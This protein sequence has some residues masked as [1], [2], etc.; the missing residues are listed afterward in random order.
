[1][2]V[3]RCNYK[4]KFCFHTSKTSDILPLD[5]ALTGLS[6][7]HQAGVGKINFAGGEPFLHPDF[8]GRL[9]QRSHELGMNVPI[10]SNGSLTTKDWMDQLCQRSHE[11]GMNV[12]IIS[13]GSLTTKEWMDQYGRYV[14]IMGVSVDSFNEETNRL[15]GRGNGTHVSNVWL[16]KYLCDKRGVKFKL[17]TV[18]CSHNWEEDMNE[19]IQELGPSRWKVFQVLL[20]QGENTG[21]AD[22]SDSIRDA[23]AL[24]VT[25][26]QFQEFLQRLS[27]QSSLVPED[28]SLMQNSYLL[29]DE[30]MRFLNCSNGS[31]EPTES[32]LEVGVKQAL[33]SSG[34]DLEAFLES[35]LCMG[36]EDE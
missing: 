26:E 5:E 22:G 24:T 27:A 2:L 8:L 11:L 19:K 1:M 33:R 28:N 20:L 31:K 7:L 32:I 21:K 15:I 36:G 17:N 4:C 29:L 14:D 18:V 23:T 12:S 6:L 13:N 10:I 30:K 16:L 9:C 34:F 25:N 3:Q 35:G